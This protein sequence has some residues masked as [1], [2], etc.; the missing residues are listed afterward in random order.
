MG[1]D[2]LCRK[3]EAVLFSVPLGGHGG[4][5]QRAEHKGDDRYCLIGGGV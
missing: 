1:K 4:G 2:S 5:A 3:W